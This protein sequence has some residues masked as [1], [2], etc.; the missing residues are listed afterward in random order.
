[1]YRHDQ[2]GDDLCS[3]VTRACTAILTPHAIALIC[4]PPPSAG[5]SWLTGTPS[6]SSVLSDAS[7]RTSGKARVGLPPGVGFT[8]RVG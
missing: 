3:A 8:L 7:T 2:E 1:M 4:A 5:T 6:T